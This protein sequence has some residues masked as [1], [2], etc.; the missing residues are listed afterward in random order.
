[1]TPA[2]RE[3]PQ[4][5]SREGPVPTGSRRVN[6]RVFGVLVVAALVG[7][8]T[9]V[10]YQLAFAGLEFAD[11]PL[12]ALVVSILLNGLIVSIAA[13]VG[14]YLGDSV[15]LG[16]PIIENWISGNRPSHR[17]LGRA[18]LWGV[19]T[20]VLIVVLSIAVFN[21]LIVEDVIDPTTF[22]EISP[23]LGALASVGAG[24]TEEMLF[25][26]GLVTLLVWLG[27]RLGARTDDDERPATWLVWGAIVVV[28]LA[29]GAAHLPA[30]SEIFRLTPAVIARAFVL[31]GVGGVVFGWLYWRRGLLAAM[32]AHFSTDIVLHALVPVLF[33]LLVRVLS[34]LLVGL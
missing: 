24:I 27:F 6:W 25:R 15:G 2:T 16:A 4:H 10:P 22:P 14:L 12:A 17:P 3:S 34:P 33:D 11:V 18:A 28:S 29:F 26:L 8:A 32:I 1:M 30:T 21:P 9:L 7:S 31:N 23:A 20:G 19:G 5:V 13:L